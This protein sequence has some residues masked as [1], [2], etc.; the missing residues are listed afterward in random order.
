MSDRTEKKKFFN[1]SPHENGI[2]IDVYLTEKIPDKSRSYIQ[3]L[4]ERGLIIIKNR[5]VNKNYRI[6]G[7][8][9]IEV[10]A[11]E[12]NGEINDIKPFRSKL[13]ILYEDDYLFFISKPP[14][15]TVHPAAGNKDRT[16]AN[17]LIYYFM[18]NNIE[19]SDTVRPG[20]VHR[21]DKDTSGVLVIAKDDNIQRKLSELFKKR[22]IKKRYIT[23]VLGHFKE[24]EGEI[25]LPIARSRIDR[26][27]MAVSIDKGR[28]STTAF[29]VNQSFSNNCS[30]IDVYPRTGRTHQIRVHLNYIGHPVIG[31]SKYGNTL[32][33]DI[34][35]QIGINRQFLHA[36]SLSFIHP[37]FNT[38]IAVDDG[39]PDDLFKALAFL[40]AFKI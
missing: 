39:L 17:A 3:K 24:T 19:L 12:G 8:E 21:L 11:L 9:T 36:S 28:E 34:A 38:P 25:I 18:E 26:K 14:G 33:R 13:N 35:D 16:L 5:P 10:E 20:I 15:L 29:K 31:D 27:K 4:I 32:T 2:R 6:H 22:M 1:A 40:E 30:L 23:L 37:V 7:D